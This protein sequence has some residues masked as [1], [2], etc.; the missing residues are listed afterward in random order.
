MLSGGDLCP[1]PRR[2]AVDTEWATSCLDAFT[3]SPS[4]SECSYPL[5]Q[6]DSS[7]L[8]YRVGVFSTLR[9]LLEASGLTWDGGAVVAVEDESVL[10]LAGDGQ[11]GCRGG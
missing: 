5:C 7:R 8:V 2:C 4:S 10:E 11:D 9:M 3:V 1:L 6:S